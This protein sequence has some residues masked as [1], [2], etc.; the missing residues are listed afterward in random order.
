MD[1]RADIVEIEIEYFETEGFF[2]SEVIGKRPLWHFR[3]LNYVANARTGEP[4]LVHDAKAL[5]QY[6]FAIRRSSHE[7]NM[8][9]RITSVKLSWNS[10][11]L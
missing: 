5:S 9:A 6:F 11:C 10:C 8:Y 2:R 3:S 7:C 1:H 4:T